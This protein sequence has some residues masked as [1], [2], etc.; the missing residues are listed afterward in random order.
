MPT[1]SQKKEIR[2][3]FRR[4]ILKLRNDNDYSQDVL[5]DLLGAAPSTISGYTRRDCKADPSLPL[6]ESLAE[7]LRVPIDEYL[8]YLYGRREEYVEGGPSVEQYILTLPVERQ[9][10]IYQWL[11]GVIQA[12]FERKLEE[13][14]KFF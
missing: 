13:Q 1:E 9:V 4:S 14:K 5:A 10:E 3:R 7:A 8:S 2:L 6:I 12:E 11:T